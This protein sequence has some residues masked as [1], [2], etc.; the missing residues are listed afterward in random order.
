MR[1]GRRAPRKEVRSIAVRHGDR[2]EELLTFL[3]CSLRNIQMKRR[4]CAA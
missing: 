1:F 3:F 4:E 2:T